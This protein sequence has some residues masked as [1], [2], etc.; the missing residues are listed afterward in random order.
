MK[1]F[2]GLTDQSGRVYF[3][4]LARLV[5]REISLLIPHT[6][7]K[8]NIKKYLVWDE[9]LGVDRLVWEGRFSITNSPHYINTLWRK[10]Y[11]V[12]DDIFQWLT[13]QSGKGDFLLLARLVWGRGFSVMPQTRQIFHCERIIL[14]GMIFFGG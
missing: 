6:R 13:D 2:H 8:I 9:F 4:L 10:C 5:W 14:S 11:L 12:W 7:Q 3:L 1:I